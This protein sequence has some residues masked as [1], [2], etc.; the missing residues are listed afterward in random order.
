MISH[1]VALRQ[2]HWLPPTTSVPWAGL[3]SA[4]N[5]HFQLLQPYHT[6]IDKYCFLLDEIYY[7]ALINH[8]TMLVILPIANQSQKSGKLENETHIVFKKLES[9]NLEMHSEPVDRIHYTGRKVS[10]IENRSI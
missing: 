6:T 3:P 9:A 5:Q 2:S 10:L 4:K 7:L 8:S 1:E